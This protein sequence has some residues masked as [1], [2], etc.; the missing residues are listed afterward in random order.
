MVRDKTHVL[1]V[2]HHPVFCEGVASIINRQP[3]MEVIAEAHSGLE[4]VDLF[5]QYRPDVTITDLRLPGMNGAEVTRTICRDFPGSKILILTDCDGDEDIYR[6]FQAGARGYLL[7]RTPRE[8]LIAAIRTLHAGQLSLPQTIAARLAERVPVAEL[9]SRELEV[10]AAMIQGQ[11]NKE[12]AANLFIGEGTVKVHV[13]SVMC[14][15]NA[16][17]RTQAAV[18]ALRRGFVHLDDA[19][20][21][22]HAGR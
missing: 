17:N 4:A 6:S 22:N 15:L 16:E 14:K 20:I 19:I 7:K 1:T 13:N 18:I 21:A 3:D 9:T 11:S 10:L 8:D 2:D 5:T 12:I